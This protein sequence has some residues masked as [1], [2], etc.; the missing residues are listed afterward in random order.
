MSKPRLF[1]VDDHDLIVDCL[2]RIL[3]D[4][5]DVVGSSQCGFAAA[6]AI[7]ATNPDLVLIDIALPVLSGIELARQVKLD[8]PTT[9]ILFVTMKT[10]KRYVVEAFR[11]GGLGYVTKQS[12]SSELLLA[13]E[14]VLAGNLF[15]SP[16]ITDKTGLSAAN[17]TQPG[18]LSSGRL[19]PRQREVL[20]LVV[21]GKSQKDI[22]EILDISVRTVEFHKAGIVDHLGLR[23]VAELTRYVQSE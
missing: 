10:D 20:E 12:A 2:V 14:S 1:V 22:A 21:K 5:F 18:N 4:R 3:S 7:R 17:V 8:S 15:V 6:K 13:I 11:V 9:R 23:T 16:R 19:T